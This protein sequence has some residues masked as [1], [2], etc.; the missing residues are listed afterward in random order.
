MYKIVTAVIIT[1]ICI[2][3]FC[4]WIPARMGVSETFVKINKIW[5]RCEKVIY[6]LV[7]L[8]LNIVYLHLVNTR[9]IGYGLTKYK[10]LLWFAI[11]MV[12]VSVSMDVSEQAALF[13]KCD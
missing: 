12:T 7:D 6:L 3:V 2:S 5:D 8:Y 9:L 13:G 11:A 4:I 10:K 1:C